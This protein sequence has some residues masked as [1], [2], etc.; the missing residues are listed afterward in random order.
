MHALE[1]ASVEAAL[2]LARARGVVVLS[3]HVCTQ[4]PENE[5]QDVLLAFVHER[6][7]T[8]EA[9]TVCKKDS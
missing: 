9:I 4:T 7:N 6:F 2:L 8:W 5:K 1:S 3:A